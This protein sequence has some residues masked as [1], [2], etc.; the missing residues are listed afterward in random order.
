MSEIRKSRL[1][2]GSC[3]V[4]LEAILLAKGEPLPPTTLQHLPPH[5]VMTSPVDGSSVIYAKRPSYTGSGMSS[6]SSPSTQSLHPPALTLRPEFP[7]SAPSTNGTSPNVAPYSALELALINVVLPHT[8]H[9]SMPLHPQ[10][11]LALLTLPPSHPQRPHPALLYILFA[12]AVRILEVGV[13]IPASPPLPRSLF[14]QHFAP[15]MPSPS[16]DPAYILQHVRGMSLSLLERA[17]HELDAGIRLVDRPFDLVRASI[18]ITRYLYSLG[19]FIEGWAIP[20][21]RL[22]VA[23][24]LHRNIGTI[25]SS[26]PSSQHDILPAPYA[27]TSE[28]FQIHTMNAPDTGELSNLRMRPVIIPPARDEVE[29]AERTMTFWAAKAQDWAA[30]IGWGWTTAMIDAEC[31]TQWPWGIGVPEVCDQLAAET[32]ADIS[33]G[34]G[35]SLIHTLPLKICTIQAA[36]STLL[37]HQTQHTCW[38]SNHLV[39][40]IVQASTSRILEYRLR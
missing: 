20:V 12:E 24:G 36:L 7:S 28:Y 2:R 26:G 40:C 4:E 32:T 17:R 18:G 30:G 10:R 35:T 15:P 16:F 37:L 3:V 31:V 19:R 33:P 9:L 22:V 1:I 13:P 21:A 29:V 11:F 6:S 23:C 38:H 14:P 39:Y 8:P 25:V 5:P 27:Q 34:N